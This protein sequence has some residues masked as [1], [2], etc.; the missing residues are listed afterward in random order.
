MECLVEFE[1]RKIKMRATKEDMIDFM[2]NVCHKYD[3]PL[4]RRT[5]R[6][7]ADYGILDLDELAKSKKLRKE[8][9]EFVICRYGEEIREKAEKLKGKP[10]VKKNDEKICEIILD[11]WDEN[12][13][14]FEAI[15]E[16]GDGQMEFSIWVSFIMA[17]GYGPDEILEFAKDNGI[18]HDPEDCDPD[19]ESDVYGALE[20]TEEVVARLREKY[21]KS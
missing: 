14:M 7:L 3:G 17:Y 18:A 12:E 6:E 16:E 5:I 11:V 8:F 19:D 9:S 13:E 20:L 2:A 15:K 1:G 10:A 21:K 4:D